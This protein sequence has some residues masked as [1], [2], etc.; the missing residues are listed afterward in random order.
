MSLGA[1]KT[2]TWTMLPYSDYIKEVHELLGR[3]E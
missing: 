1:Q 3:G 2:E